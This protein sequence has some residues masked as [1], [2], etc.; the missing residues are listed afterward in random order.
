MEQTISSR[1]WL[2]LLISMKYIS[3]I[4][5]YGLLITYYTQA[6]SIFLIL[7]PIVI[8]NFLVMLV[9]E[10]F[11]SSELALA[12]VNEKDKDKFILLNTIWHLLPLLWIWYILQRDNLIEL[13][14]PNF[15][16]CY[17]AGVF[18]AIVYFYFASNGKYYGNIDYVKYMLIYIITLLGCNFVLY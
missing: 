10:W 1:R 12:L 9:L 15:M 5:I 14:K 13:F 11:N 2:D 16:G 17:L 3:N 4:S 18:F 8:T 7:I 6:Y